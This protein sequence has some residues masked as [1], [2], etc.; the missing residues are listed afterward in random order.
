MSVTFTG[1]EPHAMSI[2][3][4]RCGVGG[5]GMVGTARMGRVSITAASGE[6]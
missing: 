3:A 1:R 5:S 2:Q 4:G 6:A